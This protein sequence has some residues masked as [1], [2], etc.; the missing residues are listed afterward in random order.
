MV[1]VAADLV[2]NSTHAKKLKIH[3]RVGKIRKTLS[4]TLDEQSHVLGVTFSSPSH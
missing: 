1:F 3:F 2:S 4:Q